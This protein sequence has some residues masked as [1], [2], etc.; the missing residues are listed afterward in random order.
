MPEI[1]EVC[2]YTELY[3]P[4][5]LSMKGAIKHIEN[6]AFEMVL[7]HFPRLHWEKVNSSVTYCNR[8]VNNNSQRGDK[9]DLQM[10]MYLWHF[11]LFFQFDIKLTNR[12][13]GKNQWI[14]AILKLKARRPWVF[15]SNLQIRFSK[16]I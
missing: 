7:P 11:I 8:T 10:V 12:A 13:K 1:L 14:Y 15:Y 16:R 9:A 3:F 4:I 5:V 6:M 2:P